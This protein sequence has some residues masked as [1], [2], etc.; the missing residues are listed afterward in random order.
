MSKSFETVKKFKGR[1]KRSESDTRAKREFE[2]RPKI[3]RTL[4]R[5]V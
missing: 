1:P 5:S 4:P 2:A 3:A